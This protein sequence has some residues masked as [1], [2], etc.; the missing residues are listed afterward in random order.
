MHDGTLG[1]SE[2]PEV[3]ASPVTEEEDENGFAIRYSYEQLDQSEV[4]GA[5][6]ARSISG[7]TS[8]STSRSCA[9]LYKVRPTGERSLLSM[10]LCPNTATTTT[11]YLWISRDHDLERARRAR[12]RELSRVVFAQDRR[13]VE[14]QRPEQLPIELRKELHIKLPDAFSVEFRRLFARIAEGP[15]TTEEDT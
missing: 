13:V 2:L 11:L 12:I 7:V 10:G 1:T 8:S 14:T 15:R 4:Y 5:G 6:G 3:E 9:H